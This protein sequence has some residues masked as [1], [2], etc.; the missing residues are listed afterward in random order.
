MSVQRIASRYAKSLIELADEMNKLD[1]VREDITSFKKAVQNKDLYNLFKNPVISSD[2][3]IKIV[4]KIFEGNYDELT[5]KFLRILINKGRET[6]LP[7]IATEFFEQY[8][9]V[10]HISTVKLESAKELSKAEIQEIKDKLIASSLT[11]DAV[12]LEVSVN[13]ELI[14]GFLVA[15]DDKIYDAS[16]KNKLNL[17]RKDYDENLYV[18]QIIAE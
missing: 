16:I 4:D 3:K 2:K 11:D 6:Y 10:K 13:P 8:K 14:G 18:S 5:M 12:E 17:L 15:F 7:E 9:R 1:K